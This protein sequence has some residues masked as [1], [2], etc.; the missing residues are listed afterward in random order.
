MTRFTRA[1][2]PAAALVA[3]TACGAT[4]TP[5]S[6]GAAPQASHSSTTKAKTATK[7]KANLTPEQKDAVGAAQDYLG[8]MAF[9]KKGLI[10][11]LS[12]DAGSG[13]KEKDAKIAVESMGVDWNKQAVKA[14]KEYRSSG[15]HFSRSGLIKQLESDAGSGFTHAQAVY[16]A[17]HS[18]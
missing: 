6:P 10:K 2:L 18:R 15:M 16:G 9:S 17:D 12:S 8:T 11:Q 14:A 13:F 4:S 5:A 3:L 7:P 1:L